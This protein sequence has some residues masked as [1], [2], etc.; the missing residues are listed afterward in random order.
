MITLN[1]PQR[2]G[3]G[4]ERFVDLIVSQ[5][6]KQ[7]LQNNILC[8]GNGFILRWKCLIRARHELH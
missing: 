7:M 4:M 6:Q 8:P 1:L 5:E 3:C 2:F